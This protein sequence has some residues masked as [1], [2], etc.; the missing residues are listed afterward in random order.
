MDSGCIGN[1][2]SGEIVAAIIIHVQKKKHLYRLYG[3]NDKSLA[4]N[5]RII[6]Y[7]TLPLLMRIGHHY[8]KISF[9]IVALNAY[10]ATVSL[11]WLEKHNPIIDYIER[12]MVFNKY[13]CSKPREREE[14]YK[15]PEIK[16][17]S[18][19]AITRKYRENPDSVYLTMLTTEQSLIEFAIL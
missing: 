7:K 2:L 11:F 8:E 6:I 15:K 5:K 18:I 19:I 16:E 12:E 4:E 17:I 3:F 1:F 13:T 9:D 14:T 10:N